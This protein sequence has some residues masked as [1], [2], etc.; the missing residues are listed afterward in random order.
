VDRQ[1]NVGLMS[2]FL[3]ATPYTS[4]KKNVSEEHNASTTLPDYT[5]EA[6]T[7]TFGQTVTTLKYLVMFRNA[8]LK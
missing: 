5:I 1:T 4:K 2:V 8:L 3:F 7:S 6:H